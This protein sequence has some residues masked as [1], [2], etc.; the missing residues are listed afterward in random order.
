MFARVTVATVLFQFIGFPVLAQPS[1]FEFESKHMG[2]TFRIVM[3]APDKATAEEAAKA[4]F[5]RV[6]EL[7]QIMSD[8]NPKSELMRLCATNDKKPGEPIPVSPDLFKVLDESKKIAAV[9]S[10]SFDVTVGPLVSLWRTSRRTQQLPDTEELARAKRLVGVDLMTLEPEKQTVSLKKPGMRLDLGGIAKGYAADTVHAVLV[11]R[12]ITNALVAASGDITV[13]DPPPGSD[14]WNI[15]IAPLA[16]GEPTRRLKLRNASVSTS[17]DLFQFVEING[18]RYSHVLDPRTGLGLTGRRSA[19]V[20][21]P[22]GVEADALT[23]V[24]SMV[25]P[26][27]RAI[28][29]LQKRRGTDVFI[30]IKETED[31]PVKTYQ[32]PGFKAHLDQ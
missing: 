14:T 2:T 23:K 5:A 27:D 15:D 4:S 24:A 7:D 20:I 29:L 21:A 11:K 28:E 30:A 19:T 10:G 17:G 32:S 31:A 22:R 3:Y 1:R 13:S 18:V 8:Y 12:K 25:N 26:P 16:K 6:T 9:A